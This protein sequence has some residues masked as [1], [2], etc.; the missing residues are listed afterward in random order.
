MGTLTSQDLF[1]IETK[2]DQTQSCAPFKAA[3]AEPEPPE[4]WSLVTSGAGAVFLATAL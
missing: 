2:I 4:P 1:F 3:T